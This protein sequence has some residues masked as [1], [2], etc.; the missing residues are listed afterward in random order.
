MNKTVSTK[1]RYTVIFSLFT[2]ISVGII[3]YEQDP[4]DY[5]YNAIMFQIFMKRR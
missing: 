5:M 3:T 1:F 2:C 4:T